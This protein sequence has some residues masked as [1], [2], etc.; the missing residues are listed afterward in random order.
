MTMKKE[1]QKPALH[2]VAH[3]G[4]LSP[5]EIEAMSDDELAEDLKKNQFSEKSKLYFAN[6]DY[7]LREIAG[8][9]V[10]V[11]VGNGV[12]QLNGMMGLNETFQF[13]W[14]QFEKP[15]TIYDVVMAAKENYDDPDG[16][17]EQDIY[18]YVGESLQYGLLKEW[19]EK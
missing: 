18:D 9:F 2:F 6:T 14:N 16:T 7:L 11:P 19:E 17:M 13:I 1:Y 5:K 10:L 4:D 3:I 12:A 15:H 8:E